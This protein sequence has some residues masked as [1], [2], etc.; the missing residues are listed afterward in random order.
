MPEMAARRSASLSLAGVITILAV[1]GACDRAWD[2]SIGKG[3]SLGN[4]LSELRRADRMVIKNRVSDQV[5]IDT[6]EQSRI[7]AVVGLFN[8]YPDKWVSFSGAGGDYDIYLY[9]GSRLLGRLG[10]TASSNVRPGE[11]TLNFNDYFRRVP[12]S[13]VSALAAQLNLLWPLP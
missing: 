4:D 13:D 8:K 11:D 2:W 7:D 10:L 3:R 12:A 1:C 5:R 9:H 6:R